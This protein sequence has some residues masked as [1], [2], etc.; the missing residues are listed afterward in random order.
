MRH[1]WHFIIHSL[2]LTQNYNYTVTITE[3]EIVAVV[4]AVVA[5]AVAVAATATA[6]RRIGLNENAIN[7]LQSNAMSGKS[8]NGRY[9]SP[10]S[11]ALSRINSNSSFLSLSLKTL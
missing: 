11:S 6:T 5:V 8:W 7:T 9:L 4:I 3:T 1:T 10:E 2:P